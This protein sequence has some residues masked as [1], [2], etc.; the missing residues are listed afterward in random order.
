M[1]FMKKYIHVNQMVIRHNVKYGKNLP[2]C[3]VQF[4]RN[5]KSKYCQSVKFKDGALVPNFE[6]PLACGAKVWVECEGEVELIGE[7]PYSVI[8]AAME[9]KDAKRKPVKV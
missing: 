2:V 6:N 1:K 5:G 4:G 8:R 7:V 9:K 3:R